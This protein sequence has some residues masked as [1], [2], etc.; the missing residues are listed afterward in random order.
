MGSG[1][2]QKN[3]C[4]I[5]ISNSGETSELKNIIQFIKRFN[6]MTY[7]HNENSKSSLHKN[8]L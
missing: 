6:I 2:I 8:A 1:S 7:K 4:V 3:D 5:A